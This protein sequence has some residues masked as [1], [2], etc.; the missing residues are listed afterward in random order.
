[1]EGEGPL[2]GEFAVR[3]GEDRRSP[4]EAGETPHQGGHSPLLLPG[5]GDRAQPLVRERHLAPINHAG[6]GGHRPPG[7]SR[8]KSEI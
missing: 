2:E 7:E 5:R 6:R 4:H 1:M 8:K 3:R